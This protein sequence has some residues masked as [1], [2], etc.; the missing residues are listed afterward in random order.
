MGPKANGKR[1]TPEEVVL[2]DTD[3]LASRSDEA[4]NTVND[5]DADVEQ[6]VIRRK[7]ST[8]AVKNETP[9]KDK[10]EKEKKSK[11]KTLSSTPV[12]I[13]IG[14]KKEN[15]KDLVD[16]EDDFDLT[17][18]DPPAEAGEESEDSKDEKRV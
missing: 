14:K 6:E 4:I 16:S 18:N 10:K 1:A 9:K 11:Q 8:K 12:K 2:S 5:S 3:E 13:K 15:K 17:T 7:V